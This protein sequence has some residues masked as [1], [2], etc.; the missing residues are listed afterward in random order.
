MAR[1][2]SKFLALLSVCA[3][4]LFMTLFAFG[5]DK[6][7]VDKPV[8]A[9][10]PRYNVQYAGQMLFITDN[11]TNKL[12]MYENEEKASKLRQVLDL[13]QTGKNEL[14]TQKDD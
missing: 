2:P 7:T 12:Y 3:V 1:N 10:F 14:T 5:A 11:V 8:A 13:T 4:G 6:P 9:P